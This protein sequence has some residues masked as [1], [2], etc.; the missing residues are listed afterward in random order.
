[1]KLNYTFLFGAGASVAFSNQ[2]S[3]AAITNAIRRK[4]N[5]DVV[6]YELSQHLNVSRGII[7]RKA[8]KI[9]NATRKESNFERIVEVFD[10]VCGYYA[11]SNPNNNLYNKQ[12][13]IIKHCRVYLAKSKKIVLSYQIMPF[14]LREIISKHIIDSVRGLYVEHDI[15]QLLKCQAELIHH[16]W[17]EENKNYVSLVSLNYDDIL[18]RSLGRLPS[19]YGLGFENGFY[20]DQDGH[21]YCDYVRLLNSHCSIVYPHGCL[22]FKRIPHSRIEYYCDIQKARKERLEGLIKNFP[23]NTI[24]G[25]DGECYYD[26]NS[27]II[28]GK[29][30]EQT[31]NKE[32]FGVYY[33]KTINDI[34]RKENLIIVVGYSFSDSHF[35]SAL[36]YAITSGNAQ[37][38]L[39]IDYAKDDYYWKTGIMAYIDDLFSLSFS[40]SSDYDKKISYK[41]EQR[42]I[43]LNKYGEGYISEKIY[44]YK[45]GY[46]CFLREWRKVLS[47]I[48]F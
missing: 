42:I 2:L 35:N 17:D 16:C 44:F 46:S 41:N 48:G 8:Y 20:K 26:F 31:I 10:R 32:P 15:E 5:W 27:F 28:S 25:Y 11:D 45:K 7:K 40:E 36:Q 34:A 23:H 38:M 22:N 13:F 12:L 29:S 33:Q 24:I 9:L 19:L 1:M 47:N 43:N 3:T 21:H 39:I 6:I 30:K 37:S 14:I 4:D 18:S